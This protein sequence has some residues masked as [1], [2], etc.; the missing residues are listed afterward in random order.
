MKMIGNATS[1]KILSV[2]F[3]LQVFAAATFA[4]EK[5]PLT[6]E[7]RVDSLFAEWD[8]WD[9]PGAALAVVKDGQVIYKRGYGSAQLEYNIPITPSTIFHVASVSKQFTAFAI[10]LLE[11]QGKLSLDD[12]IHKYLPELPDF[13]EKITIRHLIHHISGIRDQWELLAM[14]G[15]RLDDVITKEHILK[16]LRN[17]R[18]L[19]FKP[20]A[21]YLYCNSGFTLMAVIVERIT[22][23]SF[24]EWTEEN[25][26]RPLGMSNTHFHDDHEMIVK[27]RAYSYYK[28]DNGTLKNSVLSYAN[29]GATSLFTTVEDLARWAVNFEDKRVGGPE[30]IARMQEQGVLNDGKKISYARGL[31][32]GE[33]RGLRTVG[34]SG[35][36]AGFRSHILMFPDQHFAV[37]I[38]SNAAEFNPGTV[39]QKVAEIYLGDQMTPPEEKREENQKTVEVEPDVLETYVGRYTLDIGLSFNVELEGGQLFVRADGQPRVTLIPESDTIFHIREIDAQLT[40]V[41]DDDG[42][43]R[44]V[45]LK[46]GQQEVGGKRVQLTELSPDALTEFAGTYYSEE[47]GTTYVLK[48]VEGKLIATHRRHDDIALTSSG[49][50]KFGGDQ[51]FFSKLDFKR[52]EEGRISGFQLTGGRVRN[53]RF[54]KTED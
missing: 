40:F 2:V 8:H 17:Q 29:V 46:Q 14:A 52:N 32:I 54:V 38:L 44:K 41:A 47:L 18:D 22:G 35:G 11:Q 51:W 15:W 16:I 50:D 1:Y 12:D 53:L 34:H 33:Y 48:V 19:N 20:G 7:Q 24:R 10:T 23:K 36:D 4:E 3:V 27:N 30:V 9:T 31:V 49:E 37:I 28:D 25:I 26:F 43:F 6:I 39:A 42:T 13:G 45:V 5:E 21:E